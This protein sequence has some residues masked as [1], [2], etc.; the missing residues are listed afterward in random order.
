MP[1]NTNHKMTRVISFVKTSIDKVDVKQHIFQPKSCLLIL[2]LCILGCS[3][4]KETSYNFQHD[5][6]L[7][8]KYTEPVVLKSNGDQCQ[9]IVVPEYQGRVMTSTSNG[10][11]GSSYGW[12]NDKLIQSGEIQS[13]INAYGGEDFLGRA[14][15]GQFSVF[16]TRQSL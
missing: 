16:R 11:G 10:L 14:G 7:L 15:R 8:K 3:Q 12:I 1:I 4:M 13:H 5:L 2:I 9:L 6:D